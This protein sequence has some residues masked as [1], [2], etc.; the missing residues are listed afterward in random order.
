[1]NAKSK[2]INFTSITIVGIF[3]LIL[4]ELNYNLSRNLR[5]FEDFTVYRN[6]RK[7]YDPYFEHKFDEKLFEDIYQYEDETTT[8]PKPRDRIILNLLINR[9]FVAF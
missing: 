2:N 7:F 9:T 3:A 4:L 8:I 5:N 1:M 6:V